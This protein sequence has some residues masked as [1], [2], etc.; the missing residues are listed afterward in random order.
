MTTEEAKKI[1]GITG[2]YDDDE[3]ISLL[4]H[5]RQDCEFYQR[6]RYIT[7]TLDVYLDRFPSSN[8]L[9]LVDCS[10]VQSIISVKY[11]DYNDLTAE[12]P[13]ENYVL[14][15]VSEVNRLVLKRNCSWPSDELAPVNG[16]IIRLVAGVEAEKVGNRIVSSLP[17]GVKWAI[18]LQMQIVYDNPPNREDLLKARNQLLKPNRVMLI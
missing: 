3:M 2:G 14:D 15:N 9:E 18:A 8:S 7:Q 11:T 12:F 1:I 4:A 10:P 17:E 6:R 13:A 5:A 16:V